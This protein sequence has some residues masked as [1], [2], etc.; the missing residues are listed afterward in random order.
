MKAARSGRHGAASGRRARILSHT[1]VGGWV[2]SNS[3]LNEL[4]TLDV[5]TF[6]IEDLN[7]LGLNAANMPLSDELLLIDDG[8]VDFAG[9]STCHSTCSSCS[10]GTSTSSCSTSSTCSTCSSCSSTSC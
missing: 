10:C 7:A 5:G 6:E 2:M 1:C 8:S 4:R 9:T 3:L